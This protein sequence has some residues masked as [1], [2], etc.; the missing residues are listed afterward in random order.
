MF[1]NSTKEKRPRVEIRRS[2]IEMLFELGAIIGVIVS[3]IIPIKAWSSLPNKIPAHYNMTGQVDRWGSKYEIFI[4]VIAIVLIYFLM[5]LSSRYPHRFNYLIDITEQ[6]AE[7]QYHL[8]RLMVQ[9]LKAE[10]IWI[11]VYIQ[12]ISVKGAMGKGMGLGTAFLSISL[13]LVFGTIGVYIWRSFRV[14]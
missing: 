7:A 9:V 12:W 3:L 6:N 14:K 2:F 13:L 8:V 11:L 1:K 4:L 10:V 5:T